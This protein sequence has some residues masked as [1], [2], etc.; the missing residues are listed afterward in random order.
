MYRYVIK[1]LLF[2]IPTILGVILIIFLVMNLTPSTPGRIMLGPS[3]TEADVEQ[4]NHELGYDQPILQR[5]VDYVKDVF[6][7]QD[8][9]TSYYTKQPVFD[10]IWPRYI[11]T[12]KLAFIG[13]VLSTLIGVPL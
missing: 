3:A 6:I 2:L 13:I 12:I 9:G 4:L 5:Y 10:E 8:F 7:D 1:R 11:T